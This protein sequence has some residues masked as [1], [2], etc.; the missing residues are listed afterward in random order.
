[1]G[2]LSAANESQDWGDREPVPIWR[3]AYRD[4]EIRSGTSIR[5][6]RLPLRNLTMKNFIK[7]TKLQALTKGV[8]GLS[9]IGMF[10]GSWTQM[11][12]NFW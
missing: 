8:L 6:G 11:G 10:I 3:R 1:M 5:V 12:G 7:S 2:G 4:D 9:A